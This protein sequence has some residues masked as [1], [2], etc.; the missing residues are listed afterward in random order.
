MEQDARPGGLLAWQWSLYDQGHRDRGNLVLHLCTVPW[1][2]L[3]TLTV[4]A[5]PLLGP[6]GGLGLLPMVLA[7]ALQGRG[8]GREGVPP[9]P[10]RGPL[11]V[12]LRIFCEQWIT[13]PRFVLSGK[14]A[15]AYR[16]AG[17]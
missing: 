3:G 12:V 17:R 11:D 7:V 2:M 4:L 9:V 14:L 13:F 16:D 1:F 15:R 5:T 6:L 10:F 8:H